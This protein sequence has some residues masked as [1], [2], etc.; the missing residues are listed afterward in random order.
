MLEGF[1]IAL[2][3]LSIWLIPIAVIVTIELKFYLDK[4]KEK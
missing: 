1:L 4:P 3:G 2:F